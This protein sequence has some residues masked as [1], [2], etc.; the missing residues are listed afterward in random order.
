MLLLF[1]STA[2]SQSRYVESEWRIALEEHG[3]DGISP[4]PL[5]SPATVPPPPELSSLH[6]NDWT[7]AIL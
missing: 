4:V 3:L 2:A 5:E 6:F 7:L 1:W